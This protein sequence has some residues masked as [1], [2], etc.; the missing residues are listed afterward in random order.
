MMKKM[1]RGIMMFLCLVIFLTGLHLLDT[2]VL[3][4]PEGNEEEMEYSSHIAE[5]GVPCL[6]LKY[7]VSPLR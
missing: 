7:E 3:P 1:N 4:Q 5:N 2:Y 6:V